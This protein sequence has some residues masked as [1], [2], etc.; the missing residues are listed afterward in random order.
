MFRPALAGR[1]IGATGSLRTPGSRARNFPRRRFRARRSPWWTLWTGLGAAGCPQVH[2]GRGFRL[3]KKGG[4]S[5]L[6]MRGCFDIAALSRV[7]R[8]VALSRPASAATGDFRAPGRR[9]KLSIRRCRVLPVPTLS[10][11]SFSLFYSVFSQAKFRKKSCKNPK[12]TFR[13][14][15][16]NRGSFL[17]HEGMFHAVAFPF[18]Q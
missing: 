5:L 10:P 4:Q 17:P 9:S 2:R 8:K 13:K 3:K 16:K 1:M 14:S 15:E 7:L 6:F 11:R 18:K 12:F